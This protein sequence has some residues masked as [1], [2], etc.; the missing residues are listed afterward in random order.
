[1]EHDRMTISLGTEPIIENIGFE[2]EELKKTG[3]SL[4]F[5]IR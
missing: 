4:A 1:V 3:K 5:L 2:S